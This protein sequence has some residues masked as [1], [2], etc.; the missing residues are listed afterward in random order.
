MAFFTRK[1]EVFVVLGDPGD[2]P[3]WTEDRW[4]LI[5]PILDPLIQSA[6]GPAGVRS[7]QL[8]AGPGSPNQR[9]MSFG[10]IGW[11]GQGRSKWVHAAS[12]DPPELR[13]FFISTEVWAPSPKTC[14]RE[15][16]SPEVYVAVRN[17][18]SMPGQVVTFNPI[19]LIAAVL[20]LG[21]PVRQVA[22]AVAVQL[23][24]LLRVQCVRAW[25]VQF[26]S[27]GFT[28]AINDLCIT[29]LFKLGP[30]SQNPPSAEMLEGTWEAF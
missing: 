18:K 9:A 23:H 22:E 7:I 28:N 14:E 8:R 19:F 26:G 2:E 13:P 29:G 4:S 24:S 5:A 17:E 21:A 30:R 6:R 12:S 10:R 25:G 3:V 15:G 1:Y 27:A 16:Q 20:G 11:D